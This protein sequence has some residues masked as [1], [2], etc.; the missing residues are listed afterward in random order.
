MNVAV[1]ASLLARQHRSSQV[2]QNGFEVGDDRL[3]PLSFRSHSQHSLFEIRVKRKRSH[4]V[5]GKW[6]V[7]RLR[8]SGGIGAREF[9]DFGL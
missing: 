9:R 3:Y 2:R 7:F 4:Q 8:A 1:S 5:K 6:R